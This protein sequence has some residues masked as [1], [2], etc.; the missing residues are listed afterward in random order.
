MRQSRDHDGG[1][2][3]FFSFSFSKYLGGLLVFDDA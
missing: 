3:F 2:T 1:V